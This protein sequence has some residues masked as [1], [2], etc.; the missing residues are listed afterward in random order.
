MCNARIATGVEAI[1]IM[2]FAGEFQNDGNTDVAFDFHRPMVKAEWLRSVIRQFD[3]VLKRCA[4]TDT[5]QTGA[6]IP[7]SV[8]GHATVR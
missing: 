8:C 1:A 6:V 5:V 2:S 3:A 7:R 4:F